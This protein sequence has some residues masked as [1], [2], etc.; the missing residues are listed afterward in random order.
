MLTGRRRREKFSDGEQN[1]DFT[2]RSQTSQMNE[3]ERTPRHLTY[4]FKSAIIG[5]Y[6]GEKNMTYKRESTWSKEL[7]HKYKTYEAPVIQ[8]PKSEPKKSIWIAVKFVAR[9]IWQWVI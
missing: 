4:E 5:G 9:Q 2:K 8:T 7:R 6:L 3:P 1:Q